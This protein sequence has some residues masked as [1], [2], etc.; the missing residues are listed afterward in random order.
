M[1]ASKVKILIVDDEAPIRE[2]L[3]S[4]LMDFGYQISTANDGESGL[5]A[6]SEFKPDLV[7]QDIWMP[8]ELDG[9][10][11]LGRAQAQFPG[12]DFVMISGHGTIETAVKA[13][14]LGAFDFIEKP[15]SMDKIIIVIQNVLHL[16][17]EREEKLQLLNKLRRSIAL[18]GESASIM[19]IKQLIARL[20]P[21]NSTVLI[22]G[23][24]GVGK[25]LVA[26]NIHFM[27]PRASQ[28]FLE[29]H[30]GSIPDE[31][32]D[33]EFF[34]IEKGAMPGV[35]KT[36]KGKLEAASGGTIYI[37]EIA[38]MNQLVQSKLVR[39][40]KERT[41]MRFGGREQLMSDVR[42]IVSSSVPLAK[43]VAAGRFSQDLFELLNVF[44]IQMS[45]LRDRS[46]D[47]PVLVSHFSDMIS[48]EGGYFKKT[49]SEQAT[50]RLSGH[51]WPGN[52]RELKNF[53]ERIYILTPGD[54]VDVH[55]LH[56]A[57][58]YDEGSASDVRSESEQIQMKNFRDARA[59]FE[60]EY[61]VRK[62]AEYGGNISR[63]AEAIGL[64]RS[65]LHRK[66]KSY[67]IVSED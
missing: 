21:T 51:N 53:V 1:D 5:K 3:K 66:I 48:R 14:K 10:D 38:N 25:T 39:F 15:L 44:T 13:T 47:I 58:L 2:V 23:E 46:N 18:Y 65:Y 4:S 62:I 33:S 36:R 22:Q 7:F 60:K 29:V 37:E 20:A 27:S 17:Q 55:D 49:F 45:P 8:G 9:L 63:T 40:L 30:C 6:I 16:R 34:G 28:N 42:M 50:K 32:Q 12:T 31:L 52:I 56:F 54:F 64:E 35:D 26:Q 11:V 24:Q 67:G 57:G 43:E 41:F 61:L 19:E 59:Q